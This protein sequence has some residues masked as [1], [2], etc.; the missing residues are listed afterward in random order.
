MQHYKM[1]TKKR[2]THIFVI[3]IKWKKNHLGKQ[4]KD[5]NIEMEWNGNRHKK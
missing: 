3:T 1:E 4:K 2:E 5:N